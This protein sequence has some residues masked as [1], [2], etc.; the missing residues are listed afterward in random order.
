MPIL[1][2]TTGQRPRGISPYLL[3]SLYYSIFWGAAALFEPFLN[4]YFQ[5]IGISGFQIGAINALLPMMALLVSPF[6]SALADRRAW[7]SRILIVA[8]LGLSIGYFVLGLPKE[9]AGILVCS[10]FV[11]LLRSPTQPIGD[12]LVLRLASRYEIDYG[13][14]RLWG[15]FFYAG[16][17]AL[18]GLALNKVGIHWLFPV[19]GASYLVVALVAGWMEEG[20]PVLKRSQFPW[21]LFVQNRTL[22]FLYVAALLMG[23]STNIFAFSGMYMAHLGGNETLLGLLLGITAMAEVPLMLLGGRLMR[24]FG[25]MRTILI[26]FG[27]YLCAYLSGIFAGAPWVLL[28]TGVL[29]GAGFGLAFVSIVVTFDEHAP[30]NWSASVQSLVSAGM[31]GIAP[32]I[33]SFAFGAIYDLWPAGV[34]AFSAGLIALAILALLAAIRADRRPAAG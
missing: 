5:R 29:N 22:L 9:F 18:F 15:S 13:K 26:A 7:R 31:F 28:L 10:I 8:C 20:E 21:R 24:R 25:G 30:D 1:K 6:I 33:S 14:M 11:A 32:F 16:V 23:A 34:Y 4:V 12:S 27:S 17:A 19:T 2:F 3:G